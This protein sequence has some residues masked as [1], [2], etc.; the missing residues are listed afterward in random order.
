MS[1]IPKE[2]VN[3]RI[4]MLKGLMEKSNMDACLIVQKADLFYFS[5]TAQEAHL[6]ISL[7]DPPILFVR[8]SFERAVQQSPLDQIVSIASF[9]QMRDEILAQSSSRMSSLGLELDVLPVNNFRV[10][11]EL[12][13]NTEMTDVS[14]SI[15]ETRMIKSAYEIDLIKRAAEMNNDLFV[16]VKD[17]LK[18]GL[19]ELEFSGLLEARYRKNGHQGYVRVRSFNQDI[20]YGHIMSGR[21]LAVPSCSLGPTGGPG[22]HA[23]FPYGAGMKII[24]RNE[25]IQIDYVGVFEG[26]LVDQARTFF[27]GEPAS[28]FLSLHALA[29]SIQ[30]AVATGGLPGTKAE[31]LYDLA[32][33]MASEAGSLE[34]F[35]GHPM[36]V[37]FL[38]HGVGLELDELPIVGKRSPHVLQEGMVIALEPKFIL[39]G[40][41]LAGIE[42]TF[43]VT[44]T[45]ME[46]LTLF[47]D[48]IQVL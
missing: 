44:K 19:T 36:P 12:F 20:F 33:D 28:D 30:S 39:P 10:Y 5:G 35:L 46:K 4:G 26:Y 40:R 32:I 29:L 18:E 38:G 14:G 43:V 11:E 15:R 47:D 27:L 24:Q 48:E 34:G 9:S 1:S 31:S 17:I 13:P 16:S 21:H 6:F 2:E 41:G 7:A 42:N 37:P 25:P 23:S 8:K 45:G 22:P 3:R